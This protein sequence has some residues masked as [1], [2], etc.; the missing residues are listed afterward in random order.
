MK[1][2][3]ATSAPGNETSRKEGMLFIITKRLLSYYHILHKQFETDKIFL[4]IKKVN[5]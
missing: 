5:K 1:I 4:I 3:L 2:Y